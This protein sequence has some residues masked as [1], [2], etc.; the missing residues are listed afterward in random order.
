MQETS[1]DF[2]KRAS[3]EQPAHTLQ[4]QLVANL[5]KLLAERNASLIHDQANNTAAFAADES[6]AGQHARLINNKGWE[7]V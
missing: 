7:P 2:L 1:R 6:W 5:E 4:D 3:F